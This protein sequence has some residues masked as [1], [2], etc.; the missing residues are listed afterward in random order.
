MEKFETYSAQEQQEKPLDLQGVYDIIN[1][2]PILNL[3]TQKAPFS[4]YGENTDKVWQIV[5]PEIVDE[6]L[7]NKLFFNTSRLLLYE[8]DNKILEISAT[9]Q[10]GP[11]KIP[12][13]LIVFAYG[14]VD[15]NGR[16]RS[17]GKD[18][19]VLNNGKSFYG[20]MSSINVA[21]LYA[22]TPTE[23]PAVGK[24]IMYIQ[25]DGKVFF[26]NGGGDSH[27]IASAILRGNKNIDTKYLTVYKLKRNYL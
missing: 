6:Y 14:F 18:W 23:L 7:Q 9:E 10:S 17:Y 22:G 13:D 19:Q 11:I 3:Q 2:A 5:T 16:H 25:P 8:E 4:D 20:T 26:S 21:K 27:R 24:M 15:W 1:N 12:I